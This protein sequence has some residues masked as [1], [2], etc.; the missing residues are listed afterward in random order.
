MSIAPTLAEIEIA[1]RE[2]REFD[3]L[4]R[5]HLHRATREDGFGVVV[6][7]ENVRDAAIADTV[8]GKGG[9]VAIVHD[10]GD[11]IVFE[12]EGWHGHRWV[13]REGGRIADEWVIVDGA[14]RARLLGLDLADE[15]VRR[16]ASSAQHP[17][18]GELRSGRGQLGT[19][20]A[21]IVP[22]DFPEDARSVAD[23]FH[24]V[25]NARAFGAIGPCRWRG[26][27]GVDGDETS[28]AAWLASLMTALPDS[29]V[30][31]ERGIVVGDRVA[32]LWRL[33]AHHPGD[34]PGVPAAGKRVRAIGSS[35]IVSS[36]GAIVAHDLMIDELAVAA[37]LHRPVIGYD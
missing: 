33:H 10:L 8:S 25:W 18:L 27:D 3:L 19:P 22:R 37:Q 4:E 35:V 28:Y 26:P 17:P 6:G 24:R 15:A 29:V 36:D 31:I 32:L 20:T 5:T 1:V 13:R 21:A 7:R 16:G 12:T 34:G 23:D 30:M 2:R 14:A 11:M 9:P